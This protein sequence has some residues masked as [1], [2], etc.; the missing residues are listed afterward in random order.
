MHLI[1]DITFEKILKFLDQIKRV[2]KQNIPRLRL[3]IEAIYYVSRAGCQWRLLP[4]YYGKWRTVHKRFKA[5]SERGIWKKIFEIGKIDPD[6]ELTMTDSTIVRAH[7]CSAGYT[8]YTQPQEALGRSKGGFTTKIHAVV[9]ALGNPLK[10]ILT[11]G[12]RNDILS[13]GID[14]EAMAG[15]KAYD[16]NE[17]IDYL[18]NKGCTPAIPSRNNRKIPREYDEHIYKERNKIECFF[19]KIKHFRRVFS[20][21]DKAARSYLSFIYFVSTLIWLR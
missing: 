21:Y 12:Q 4:Y 15:D 19:G 14:S 8:K 5:W 11:P 7:A 9:D 6:M 3:F 13:M 17:Y 10:F 20:R 16:A 1:Q 18:N 2:H